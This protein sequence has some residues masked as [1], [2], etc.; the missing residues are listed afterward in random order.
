[1][2]D[3][4]QGMGTAQALLDR[5]NQF[6]L[7]RA[8][9]LKE[10]VDAG[11]QLSENDVDFLHRVLEDASEARSL[12]K[13]HPEFKPLIDQMASLYNHITTKA[14]ENEQSS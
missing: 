14:L 2:Q 3:P 5:L 7:P 8:L 12:M 4:S 10:R 9:D 13:D 11:E 6:R 1:M